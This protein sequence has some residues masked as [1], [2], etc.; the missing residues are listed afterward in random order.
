M[1]KDGKQRPPY[2]IKLRHLRTYRS[3][4]SSTRVQLNFSPSVN[5]S[6]SFLRVLL[7]HERNKQDKLLVLSSLATCGSAI[8][9]KSVG[10]PILSKYRMVNF[11]L[12]PAFAGTVR[13]N[14]I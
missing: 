3:L 6:G 1:L 13:I 9:Q 12:Y 7:I 4:Q 14:M 8:T 2:C 11:I 10:K 5:Q